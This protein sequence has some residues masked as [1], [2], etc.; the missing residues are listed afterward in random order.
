MNHETAIDDY[1]LG[2]SSPAREG[3]E[4]LRRIIRAAAPEAQERLSYRMP[5]YFQHGPLVYFAGFKNHLGFYPT[6]SGI[7]E[8]EAEL[9]GYTHS[10]GAIQFPIGEPLPADLISRIVRFRLM[11]NEERHRTPAS[12]APFM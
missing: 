5:A 2:F 7:A 8:F 4:E 9:D 12:T 1:I 11:E 6:S 3:L 10:K